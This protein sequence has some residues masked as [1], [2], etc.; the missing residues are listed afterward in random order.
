M[1][2]PTWAN[3]SLFDLL[4]LGAE[5]RGRLAAGVAFALVQG[6]V[7]LLVPWVAGRFAER[8]VGADVG[9]GIPGAAYAALLVALFAVHAF[10][11]YR[12]HFLTGWTEAEVAG[13]LRDRLYDRLQALP[14]GWVQERPIGDLLAVVAIDVEAVA[15]F[16]T[17]VLAGIPPLALT[18]IGALALMAWIDP[19]ISLLSALLVPPL[20]VLVRLQGR[21]LTTL[22]R[23]MAEA[24]GRLFTVVQENLEHLLTIKVFQRER[25]E[26]LRHRERNR[27]FREL[28]EQQLRDQL[29]IGPTAQCLAA[30][31]LVA[32][33]AVATQPGVGAAL[34]PGELVALLLYALLLSRL[35]AALAQFYAQVQQARAARDRLATFFRTPPEPAAEARNTRRSPGGAVEFR[36]VH[37]AYPGRAPTLRGLE[38]RVQPGELVALVGPNGGGKTTLVHL[39]MRLHEGWRGAILV[40]GRDV[41]SMALTELRGQVGLATQ[42]TQLFDRSIREN[43]AYARAG[44]SEPEIAQAARRAGIHDFIATLPRGY[45][46]RV[47]EKGIRLSGGQRQRI[48]LARTLL[49]DPPILV[50][51]EA[52]SMLDPE[53]EHQ[54]LERNLE[55][56]RRRTVL[57]ITHRPSSLA[58]ADRIVE[59]REGTSRDRSLPPTLRKGGQRPSIGVA[60][61]SCET[62][63]R[64]RSK[65]RPRA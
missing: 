59:I 25:A 58:V 18:L 22:S 15:T 26:S 13:S 1:A 7:L 2:S 43:I 35:V 28:R 63:R 5:H 64:I 20:Y 3:R 32:L 57:L 8:V 54:F 14:L 52:T 37:F 16:S 39:L 49:R 23:R 56:L 50:L 40:D 42:R 61:A 55:W 31:S 41:R 47:G 30:S 44:A 33:V 29:R 11:S 36:D 34:S 62:P 10:A 9:A 53:G 19:R 17:R 48:A 4:R 38:L 21:N 24:H 6:G 51:D 45:D 27:A 60:G 46:T 65:P 12:G